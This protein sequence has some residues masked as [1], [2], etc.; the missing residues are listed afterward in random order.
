MKSTLTLPEDYKEIFHLDLQR[1]KKIALLVNILSLVLAIAMVLPALYVVPLSSILVWSDEILTTAVMLAKLLAI[2]IGMMVYILLHELVHGIFMRGYSKIRPHYGFTGLYAYAGSTAY[3]NKSAYLVIAL[4]PVIIW[5]I[6]LAA[7]CFLLPIEWFW[8]AYLIE[9]INVS[10][11][12]GDL[13]VTF[14]FLRMPKDILVQD[15]GVAMTVYA[16]ETV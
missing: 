13:Y 6:V 14:R 12:A 10:G 5:G 9:V 1:D 15:T 4:A 8:V 11:A 16:K 3:F 2:S 7:L